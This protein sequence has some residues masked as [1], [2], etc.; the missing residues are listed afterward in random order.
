MLTALVSQLGSDGA[1]VLVESKVQSPRQ[2]FSG[3]LPQSSSNIFSTTQLWLHSANSNRQAARAS[4]P[5]GWRMAGNIGAVRAV[6]TY[7]PIS[8]QGHLAHGA[9]WIDE[10]RQWLVLVGKTTREILL[11]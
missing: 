3:S 6:C 4:S 10:K 5:M 2:T 11:A 1:Q 8:Y 7:T 9:G